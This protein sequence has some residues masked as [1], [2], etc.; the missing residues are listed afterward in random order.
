M[1]KEEII[2]E[3]YG[4]YFDKMKPFIDENGWFDK[5]AFYNY[6][7]NLSYAEI[8]L[9]FEHKE[10][11]MRPKSLSGIENNNGWIKLQGLPN[12]IKD[13]CSIWIETKNGDIEYLKENEFLPVG[14][15]VAYKVVEKPKKRIY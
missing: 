10:D 14:Y 5:N 9:L 6:K 8:D 7:F 2:K 15:A 13:R 1:T 11:F 12:E 4:I 3:G